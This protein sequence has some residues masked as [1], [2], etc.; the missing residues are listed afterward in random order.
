MTKRGKHSK[1][2]RGGGGIGDSRE[3]VKTIRGHQ[4][5]ANVQ[6]GSSGSQLFSGTNIV[7][8]SPDS[9]GTEV[10]DLA[11]HFNQFCF[12]KLGIEYVPSKYSQASLA[13]DSTNTG[14]NNIF[15]FGYENDSVPTF[16]V[17]FDNICALQ[18]MIVT[19]T[20]GYR[21]RGMNTLRVSRIPLKWYYTK[22]NT[23]NDAS[24]RQTIQGLIYG[25]ARTAITTV[26]DYG[27]LI[28]HYEIKFR[29]L[30]PTQSVTLTA[31]IR[32]ARLGRTT[33]LSKLSLMIKHAALQ[34]KFKGALPPDIL[35]TYSNEE[36]KMLGIERPLFPP[37]W[38]ADEAISNMIA[39]SERLTSDLETLGTNHANVNTCNTCSCR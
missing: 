7:A 20:V 22:D 13:A 12:T 9:M 8:L 32:E 18:H 36:C 29:D 3:Q 11:N 23:T 2:R 19:P 26:T 1:G 16:T 21:V 6:N 15:A 34:S 4:K 28:I 35:A 30:C 14:L 27:V 5:Y 38:G 25:E 10:A 37:D 31:L 17:T 33:A 39:L 24:T